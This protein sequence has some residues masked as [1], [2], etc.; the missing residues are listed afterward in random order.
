M[1]LLNTGEKMKAQAQ[2]NTFLEREEWKKWMLYSSYY[3]VSYSF[4]GKKIS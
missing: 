2:Y 3:S 1:I 4:N